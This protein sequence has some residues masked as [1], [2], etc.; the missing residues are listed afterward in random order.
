VR[1]L[2]STEFFSE[3]RPKDYFYDRSLVT[4]RYAKFLPQQKLRIFT[5]SITL[6]R[7]LLLEA[8][9]RS[10]LKCASYRKL[11]T[12]QQYRVLQYRKVDIKCHEIWSA[13][14]KWWFQEFKFKGAKENSIKGKSDIL[15]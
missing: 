3:L 7:F 6:H 5:T 9:Y 8:M 11:K 12:V 15:H 1:L 10:A 13:G 2:E 4:S 14:S